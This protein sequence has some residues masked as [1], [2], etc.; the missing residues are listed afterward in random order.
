MCV[1]REQNP[2]MLSKDLIGLIG[3]QVGDVGAETR[4]QVRGCWTLF[5]TQ[6]TLRTAV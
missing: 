2:L 6:E 4:G 1:A 5:L 3:P